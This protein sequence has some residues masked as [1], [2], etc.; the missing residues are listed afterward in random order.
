M[1]SGA[2]MGTHFQPFEAHVPFK[3]QFCID[4]NLYGMGWIELEGALLRNNI[5]GMTNAPVP[6]LM[7]LVLFPVLIKVLF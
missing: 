1:R 6:L 5:A 2:I 3:L 4:F 7:G